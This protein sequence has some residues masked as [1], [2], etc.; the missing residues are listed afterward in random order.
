VSAEWVT[1]PC[2]LTLRSEF[3]AIAEGRPK[4]AD[5]TI[6]D[7]AHADRVSDHNP[8]ETGAVPVRDADHLNEVHALDITTYPGLDKAVRFILGRCRS[9]AEKRLR[10]IIWDHEIFEASS[11]W[12]ARTYDGTDPH[13]GH[14]HFSASYETA[15][16]SDTRSWHLGD[17]VP[18]T[19]TDADLI[20]N[21]LW[22]KSVVAGGTNYG[23]FGGC[24]ATLMARTGALA[25]TMNLNQV[26]AEIDANTVTLA[27]IGGTLAQITNSLDQLTGDPAAGENVILDVLEYHDAHPSG[28]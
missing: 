2:L 5:G 24:I 22:G 11:D 6:G 16:E 14:A 26:D 15:R 9:G 18:I 1:V 23:T 19:Q 28:A 7:Q 4:G 21:T 20:V 13:T 27:T 10:Y 12:R 8:D 17:L 3:N 25:N